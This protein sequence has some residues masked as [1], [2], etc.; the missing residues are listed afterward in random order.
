MILLSSCGSGGSESFLDKIKK[1]AKDI[2]IFIIKNA[3]NITYTN[4][5][6]IKKNIIIS[7][8]DLNSNI[9][10]CKDLGFTTFIEKKDSNKISIRYTK[11]KRSCEIVDFKKSKDKNIHGEIN[12]ILLLK[13]H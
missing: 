3:S 13:N 1:D 10:N 4:I 9:I 6:S 12:K 5:E 7:T 2:S 8:K 11:G